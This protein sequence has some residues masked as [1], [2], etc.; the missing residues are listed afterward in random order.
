MIRRCLPLLQCR[1]ETLHA[2]RLDTFAGERKGNDARESIAAT[3]GF[4]SLNL[5]REKSLAALNAA[6]GS[7]IPV[8]ITI[9]SSRKYL[10]EHKIL[11]VAIVR[12]PSVHLPRKHDRPQLLGY[13]SLYLS[14]SN[15]QGT[16]SLV[17][18]QS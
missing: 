12:F 4:I 3:L 16:N 1:E 5:K 9:G 17:A 18:N 10:A 13:E 7:F 15:I 11:H 8:D 14:C 6:R 2:F